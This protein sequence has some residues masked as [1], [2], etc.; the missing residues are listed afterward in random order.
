M[1]SSPR[2]AKSAS[3]W[4][5]AVTACIAT[6]ATTW[7]VWEMLRLP[8]AGSD[9]LVVALAVGAV[10][11]AVCGGPLFSWAG[12]DRPGDRPDRMLSARNGNRA[13]E[14]NAQSPAPAAIPGA[15][16]DNAP[17]PPERSPVPR[18]HVFIS[19][20]PED[21]RQVD[22]IQ[23]AIMDAGILV[24]RDTSDVWPG[25]DRQEKIQRAIT[26]AAAFLVCF[27]KASLARPNGQNEQIALAVE[28]LKAE[29]LYSSWLIPARLD[30]CDLPDM[31]LGSGRRLASIQGVDLFGDRS[32][33]GMN[34]LV[35]AL[36]RRI[37]S[38]SVPGRPSH[39][40]TS[41]AA[42]RSGDGRP[43][44]SLSGRRCAQRKPL[45]PQNDEFGRR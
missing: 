43:A 20:S 2:P 5:I 11:S 12:Q 25:E 22:L 41:C 28:Q 24:W 44:T 36:L 17:T 3:R 37:G 9:R 19:Y 39:K 38:G 29:R 32:A 14:L 33:Q 21:R 30:A 23:E 26:D 13:H 27:S 4:L 34:R 10:A 18:A 7:C 15:H 16:A 40:G 45:A 42:L 1:T 8:P 6:F 31:D 35:S